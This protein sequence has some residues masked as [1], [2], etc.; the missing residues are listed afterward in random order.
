MSKGTKIDLERAKEISEEWINKLS[1]F[2][3]E[4]SNAGTVRREDKESTNDI[5]IVL[6]RDEDKFD[7]FKAL[8]DGLEYVSGQ[9][10]GSFGRLLWGLVPAEAEALGEL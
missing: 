1:P 8:I 3:L 4:I 5:D 2:C 10:D 6:I 9:P 7:E